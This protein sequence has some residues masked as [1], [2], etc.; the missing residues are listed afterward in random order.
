M[1]NKVE[2]AIQLW[3]K[4]FNALEAK[5]SLE[6]FKCIKQFHD[7]LETEGMLNEKNYESTIKQ[8]SKQITDEV[9]LHRIFSVTSFLSQH[10]AHGS[11]IMTQ[12]SML[13]ILT[14]QFLNYATKEK[15]SPV[16]P[17]S[18]IE[19]D[20]NIAS[21]VFL[22]CAIQKTQTVLI[23]GKKDTENFDALE[24]ELL[25]IS[26]IDEV[27]EFSKQHCGFHNNANLTK[28]LLSYSMKM[29]IIEHDFSRSNKLADIPNIEEV[30][31]CEDAK[32]LRQLRDST[33]KQYLKWFS[34]LPQDEKLS[35]IAKVT[36]RTHYNAE[37]SNQS[38]GKLKAFVQD[39][40][41][42]LLSE[43]S[44]KITEE[45]QNLPPKTLVMIK[46]VV[47]KELAQTPKPKRNSVASAFAYIKGDSQKRKS[48]QFAQEDLAS[49]IKTPPVPNNSKKNGY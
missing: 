35:V 40:I 21:D 37:A 48:L 14:N 22:Y 44:F 10:S 36:E 12:I 20:T 34:G 16:I 39:I 19:L 42:T 2:K 41:Y 11:D 45:M 25:S 23:N 6:F 38:P 17:D 31:R 46:T 18:T 28:D 1:E 30:L 27:M 3:E 33:Q 9:Y 47:D 49:V 26:H 24:K 15:F 43:S 8:H 4:A 5:H 29:F 7:H 13:K 32:S